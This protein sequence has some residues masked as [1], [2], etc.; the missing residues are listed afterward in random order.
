M[1]IPRSGASNAFV[2]NGDPVGVLVHVPG[3]FAQDDSIE[4]DVTIVDGDSRAD[5]NPGDA[6][7]ILQLVEEL[8]VTE[9]IEAAADTSAAA[10]STAPDAP[11][12][13][14]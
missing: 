7:G 14:A 11:A 3:D 8:S 2:G 13:G 12:P 5:W 4:L 6:L 10:S 9:A 1:T